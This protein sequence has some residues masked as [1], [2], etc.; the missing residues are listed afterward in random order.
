MLLV[1]SGVHP[2]P[3]G[4]D[5][6]RLKMATSPLASRGAA[7]LKGKTAPVEVLACITGEEDLLAGRQARLAP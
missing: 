4:R 1:L 5:R 2:R 7:P 6:Y 3:D